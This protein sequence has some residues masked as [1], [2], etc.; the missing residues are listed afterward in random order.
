LPNQAAIAGGAVAL[1]RDPWVWF[2]SALALAF[3]GVG[4]LP[5]VPAYDRESFALYYS[6][7]VLMVVATVVLA[8]CARATRHPEERIF[9]S[10]FT[11]AQSF[12]LASAVAYAVFQHAPDR[13]LGNLNT[14]LLMLGYY[15]AL[16]LGL[17]YRPHRRAGW[18][19]SGGAKRLAVAGSLV[20]AVTAFV[21]F[22]VIP[23]VFHPESYTSWLPTYYFYLLLDVGVLARLVSLIPSRTS[24]RWR[25]TYG[26]LAGAFALYALTD[27]LNALNAARVIRLTAGTWPD[28]FYYAPLVLVVAAART[29]VGHVPRAAEPDPE[30]VELPTWPGRTI[31]SLLYLALLPLV[32]GALSYSGLLDPATRGPRD[33]VIMAST[34]VLLYLAMKERGTLGELRRNAEE[35]RAEAQQQLEEANESLERKVEARTAQFRESERRYRT[36][37]EAARDAILQFGSD[38][39]IEYVNAFGAELLGS[40]VEQLVGQSLEIALPEASPDSGLARRFDAAFR[41]RRP[42]FE[43]LPFLLKG[44]ERWLAVSLVPLGRDE[45]SALVIARDITEQRKTEESLRQAQKM[46]AVGQLA[47]GIAH[48]FNNLIGVISGYAEMLLQAS[49]EVDP[50]REWLEQILTAGDRAASLTRQLLAFGRKQVLQPRVVDVNE[51]LRDMV[52]MLQRVIGEDVELRFLPGADTGEVRVDSGLLNQVLINLATNARDAMP[53]GGVL[54]I[55]TGR[56]ELGPEIRDRAPDLEPGIF[57]TIT[58]SDTGSGMD[59]ATRAHVF[60]PFFTTKEV[61]KGTGLGLATVYGIVQQSGGHIEVESAPGLGSTFRVFLPILAGHLHD[62]DTEQVLR[63]AERGSAGNTVLVVED[64]EAVRGVTVALV[65]SQ[66]YRALAAGSASEAL[67]LL[68]EHAGA[69]DVLLTDVVMPQ[70]DGVELAGHVQARHPEIRVI[71]A[72]GFPADKLS[73]HGVLDDRV[74]LLLKPLSADQLAHALHASLN[75]V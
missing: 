15:S 61:G 8:R 25:T 40:T 55:E 10:W 45:P 64:D 62:S 39:R 63:P 32:H 4:Y 23:S 26:L 73:H 41:R 74:T 11:V 36:L 59:E 16:F 3:V 18:S 47:G 1:R 34:A 50:R 65:E 37:I 53:T 19:R 12:A 43:E 72:S 58:V 42:V 17:L 70:A 67:S 29:S 57:T 71:Y 66:G 24:R 31:P 54:T 56:A 35:R 51:A 33:L 28:V 75:S 13:T 22:N 60:E 5:M 48:D 7:L 68:D 9:W 38:R 49:S 30:D 69:I 52:T 2:I 21:Y 6:Q 14:Q 27:M 46:E 44:G 20:V